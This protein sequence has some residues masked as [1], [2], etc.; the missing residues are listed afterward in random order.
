MPSGNMS[1]IHFISIEILTPDEKRST[2]FLPV[3]ALGKIIG[4]PSPE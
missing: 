4:I 3:P 1:F 2:L